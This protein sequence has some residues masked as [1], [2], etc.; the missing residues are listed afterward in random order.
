MLQL[1]L[2]LPLLLVGRS[3]SPPTGLN[4]S[5]DAMHRSFASAQVL[6]AS[7]TRDCTAA[8]SVVQRASA[9]AAAAARARVDD[10]SS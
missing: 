6:L 3:I 2:L 8:I 4:S 1:L 9:T 5:A 7:A 10:E